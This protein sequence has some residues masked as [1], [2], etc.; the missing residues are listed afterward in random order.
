[1]LLP[2]IG[3]FVD[4]QGSVA[5][6]QE[7]LEDPFGD[8]PNFCAVCGI[9]GS[10]KTTLAAFLAN[11]ERRNPQTEIIWW[12]SGESEQTIRQGLMALAQAAGIYSREVQ[13]PPD[14]LP[15]LR[16]YLTSHRYM[17]IYDAV[18]NS[19]IFQRVSCIL[20]SGRVLVTTL[21]SDINWSNR[22]VRLPLWRV[23][24][25]ESYI[26]AR[27]PNDV[28]QGD[29]AGLARLLGFLPLALAQAT[30]YIRLARISI[31]QYIELFSTYDA[32]LLD[33]PDS[34]SGAVYR[35][36][37]TVYSTCGLLLERLL[38]RR[39]EAAF[40]AR[41]LA[42]L[43]HDNI[44]RQVV[45]E[46]FR[47]AAT[48]ASQT[49]LTFN[50]HLTMLGEHSLV[51]LAPHHISMHQLI[52]RSV[53][54]WMDR[55]PL[56]PREE[57]ALLN[58]VSGALL[59]AI[60]SAV[61]GKY[62]WDEAHA[63]VPH[64]MKFVTS[65]R[66]GFVPP[67]Q[68][69]VRLAEMLGNLALDVSIF[70]AIGRLIDIASRM[71]GDTALAVDIVRL[72]HVSAVRGSLTDSMKILEEVA[73]RLKDDMSRLE[74]VAGRPRRGID[75]TDVLLARVRAKQGMIEFEWGRYPEAIARYDEALELLQKCQRLDSAEAVWILCAAGRSLDYNGERE[76]ALAKLEEARRRSDGA[77]FT[78]GPLQ[79]EVRVL[80]GD[81]LLKLNRRA[82][83]SSIL[84]EALDIAEKTYPPISGA[85]GS[86]EN[87]IGNVS[88]LSGNILE[89]A[90][91]LRRGRYA[92]G[93]T[94]GK[95]QIAYGRQ[96]TDVG[97]LLFVAGKHRGA[98]RLF[99]QAHA[100]YS[101]AGYH[102]GSAIAMFYQATAWNRRRKYLRALELLESAIRELR[103][104]PHPDAEREALF[105]REKA[106]AFLGMDELDNA[107][108][109]IRN[110]RHIRS[111]LLE[112][113]AYEVSRDVLVELQCEFLSGVQQSQSF[114]EEARQEVE[115]IRS[116]WGDRNPSV[117]VAEAEIERLRITGRFSVF[118]P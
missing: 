81:V 43:H 36:E 46:A 49:V 55:H 80:T 51:S 28:I 107:L 19:D 27:V 90:G 76:K 31:R 12:L 84:R 60:P 41:I 75:E 35:I 39:P 3:D 100:V 22:G 69:V 24:E 101:N 63:L 111:K 83:S 85:F 88:L 54:I 11:R 74:D 72:S 64:V 30:Q 112:V 73:G 23:D 9:P 20:A 115:N 117:C 96:L 79:V 1:L 106:V 102:I 105:S 89:A 77:P 78:T 103:Q 37:R 116:M 65:A 92:I 44:P 94:F 58:A 67:D 48:G 25:A 5:R 53:E 6:V 33:W 18:E 2:D 47:S 71:Y 57:Q 108:D 4:Q 29:E 13:D 14:L 82:P 66:M 17:L 15:V 45:F 26:R 104:L 99:E 32:E 42:M 56:A 86:L 97:R 110:A 7:L 59:Q 91:N 62:Y 21:S 8:R 40:I 118:S 38:R 95:S 113:D 109:A 87:S 52:H 93:A 61:I 70:E 98:L 68:L 114:V 34:T 10:G 16:A 50:S